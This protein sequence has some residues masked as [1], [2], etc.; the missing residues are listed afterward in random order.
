MKDYS[1]ISTKRKQYLDQL[2][3]D[4]GVPRKVVYLAA[5]ILGS[6]EDYDGLISH[7]EELSEMYSDF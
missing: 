2:A 6:N 4:Y 3:E 1:H 5:S 7:V